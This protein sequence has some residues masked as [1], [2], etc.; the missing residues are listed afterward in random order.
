MAQDH[1][2]LSSDESWLRCKLKQHCLFLASLERT[3]TR[4]HSRVRYLKAS[5]VNTSFFHKQ[6]GFRKRKNFISKLVEGDRVA[7]NQ[8]GKHQVL[9]NHFDGVLGKAR[10]RSVTFDLAGFHRAGIDLSALDEPFLED[11]SGQPSNLYQLIEH[12]VL[13]GILVVFI[14]PAGQ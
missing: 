1:R 3:I 6:A 11:E 14:K 13:M 10:T 5:D 4:L 2:A 7:I 8:E 12:Q 9:F